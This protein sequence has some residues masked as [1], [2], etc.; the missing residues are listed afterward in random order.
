[1]KNIKLYAIGL[2]G[3]VTVSVCGTSVSAATSSPKQTISISKAQKVVLKNGI[4]GNGGDAKIYGTSSG[5]W[6]SVK[7]NAFIGYY[8]VGE[9][10]VTYRNASYKPVTLYVGGVH[11]AG[12]SLTGDVYFSHHSGGTAHLYGKAEDV[13]G[14]TFWTLADVQTNF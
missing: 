6:W 11:T 7:P 2:L 9:V 13:L 4:E 8:F 10:Y 3:I 14:D 5:A 12:G 1:M